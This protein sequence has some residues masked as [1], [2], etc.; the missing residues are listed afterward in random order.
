LC[1]YQKY[2][3]FYVFFQSRDSLPTQKFYQKIISMQQ[4]LHFSFKMW[5]DLG[6]C[7]HSVYLVKPYWCRPRDSA[8]ECCCK[9]AIS[10][11]GEWE[12]FAPCVPT[13][14]LFDR[15]CRFSIQVDQKV[16]S[17][18]GALRL[19][20]EHLLRVSGHASSSW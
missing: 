2:K 7:T 5:S 3:T 16:D 1:Q 4:P 15:N 6:T 10:L 8:W 14:R 19:L 20:K 18:I 17:F 13:G 12:K 9:S 11:R